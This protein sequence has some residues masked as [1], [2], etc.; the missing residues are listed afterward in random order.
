MVLASHDSKDCRLE[1]G[2][3]RVYERR[4]QDER[5]GQPVAELFS[6]EGP[7]ND[8]VMKSKQV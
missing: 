8:V 5:S 4:P 3:E 2:Y 7:M 6:G 1:A